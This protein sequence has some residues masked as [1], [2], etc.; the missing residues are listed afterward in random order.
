MDCKK[1]KRFVIIKALILALILGAMNGVMMIYLQLVFGYFDLMY[2]V[3][4][5]HGVV[6]FDFYYF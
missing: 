1:A 4:S 2:F 6:L 5:K 3:L